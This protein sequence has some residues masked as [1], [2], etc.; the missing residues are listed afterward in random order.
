M[1][2]GGKGKHGKRAL[3]A[4]ARRFGRLLG[5][6]IDTPDEAAPTATLRG[7]SKSARREED[8]D[9]GA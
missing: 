8:V 3:E 9:R 1:V 4:P 5:S 2:N 7:M 6:R